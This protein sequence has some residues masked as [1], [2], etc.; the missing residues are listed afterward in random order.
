MRYEEEL[1]PVQLDAVKH[2]HGPLLVVAGAGSGKTRIITYRIAHLIE[3]GIQ[4]HSI[5]GVTF[6]NKAADEMRKR[7][8]GLVNRS[9]L[10]STFHSFCALLLRKEIHHLGYSRNYVIYDEVDSRNLVKQI[11]GG[12]EVFAAFSPKEIA[13]S[14]SYA[15]NRGITPRQYAAKARTTAEKLIARSYDEYQRRLKEN[16]AVDFDDLLILAVELLEKFPEV[17]QRYQDRYRYILVDEYQDTNR[18]QYRLIYLLAQKHKNICAVGDPDQSIYQWRGADITNILNFE[19]DFP[20]ATVITLEQNYRSTGLILEAANNVIKHNKERK[21]KKLWSELEEGHKPV[22]YLAED[23]RLETEF[24]ANT[25]YELHMRDNI[26]YRDIAVFY[27]TNAQSRVFEEQFFIY[28]IPFVVIGNVGFYERKEIKDIVAYL[29]ILTAPDDS[30][31]LIRIINTP[32]RGIGAKTIERI[33]AFAGKHKLTA[34]EALKRIDEVEDVG[35]GIRKRISGFVEM[36]EE[37]RSKMNELRPLELTRLLIEK[38][39]FLDDLR[40]DRERGEDRVENVEEFLSAISLFEDECP[41]GTLEEFLQQTSLFSDIDSWDSDED[42]VALMTMHNSKGLEFPVVFIPGLEESLSPHQNSLDSRSMLEEERRL[43]YVCLTR[44]KERAYLTSAM[45]RLRF[46][47]ITE[48][49]PSRFIGEITDDLLEKQG[50]E[51]VTPSSSK[52]FFV[53]SQDWDEKPVVRKKNQAA[54]FA[55]GDKVGHPLYGEG[56]VIEVEESP[57]GQLC[58]IRFLKDDETKTIA[59]K[60][61]RMTKL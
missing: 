21:E 9:P 25:V 19:R 49:F 23:D 16:G 37:F 22:Y 40:K 5:L 51:L 12:D 20:G 32:P 29:R 6:T 10:I 3:S 45:Q 28:K 43:F 38:V 56:A 13:T 14:I 24:V 61:A 48:R 50:E 52:D 34:H 33:G 7:V 42:R 44:A 1:N 2:I 54:L 30:L 46:G 53:P 15:K 18:L 26:P 55:E 47:E 41:E 11:L 27:R 17:L 4:P 57:A 35:P 36:L 8:Q 60:F 59:A 31:S 39:G 58:R